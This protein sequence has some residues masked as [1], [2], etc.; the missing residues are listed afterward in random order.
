ML[1]SP[2]RAAKL[3][4]FLSVEF[5]ITMM[6]GEWLFGRDLEGECDVTADVGNVGSCKTNM[7]ENENENENE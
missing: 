4:S 7:N 1:F 5:D 6:G 2:S 3:I